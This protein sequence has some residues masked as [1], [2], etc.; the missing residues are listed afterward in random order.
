MQTKLLAGS[1]LPPVFFNYYLTDLPIAIYSAGSVP[2]A[3]NSRMPPLPH[4]PAGFYNDRDATVD[5]PLD[6][7]KVT[8]FHC[9]CYYCGIL[10]FTSS[11]LP[12]NFFYHDHSF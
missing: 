3:S 10:Y 11:V 2:A 12:K 7:S 1:N 6:S 9:F 5:I 4:E 8:D